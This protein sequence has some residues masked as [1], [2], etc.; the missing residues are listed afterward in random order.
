MRKLYEKLEK[1][2]RKSQEMSILISEL[3][4]KEKRETKI[5]KFE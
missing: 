2:K 4:E 3:G 5:K 1:N